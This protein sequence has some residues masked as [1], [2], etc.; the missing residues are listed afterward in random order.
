MSRWLRVGYIGDPQT[1]S[2]KLL[3]RALAPRTQAL[4]KFVSSSWNQ[5]SP[6]VAKIKA[7][8]DEHS[9]WSP[10]RQPLFPAL[11]VAA[12]ASNIS[13]WMQNVG[14]VWLMTSH[15]VVFDWWC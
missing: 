2:E 15:T 9:A 6:W 13:T 8:S 4:T 14:G 10:L 3:Q 5:T 11:W 12:V 7:K 1:L